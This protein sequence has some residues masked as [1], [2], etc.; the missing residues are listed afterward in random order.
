MGHARGVRDIGEVHVSII[1]IQR[2][3]LIAEVADGD[4]HATLV[5]EVA[6]RKPHVGLLNAI[7]AEGYARLRSDLLEVTVTLIAIK[8]VRLPIIGDKEINLAVIVKVRPHGSQAEVVFAV[9]DPSLCSDLRKRAVAV[10]VVQR[11]RRSLQ[12]ARAA[13]HGDVVILASLCRPE[14]RQIVEIEVDVMR[15]EEIGKTI[16]IVVPKC[17]PGRPA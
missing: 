5:L 2:H 1:S 10:V 9:L 14:Q 8:I 3:V 7:L 4:A 13:L 17:N 15:D 16:A 6:D 11:V 12:P